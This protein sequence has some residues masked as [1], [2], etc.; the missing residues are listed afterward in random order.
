VPNSERLIL[1]GEWFRMDRLEIEIAYFLI[2]TVDKKRS[3]SKVKR[4]DF[5]EFVQSDP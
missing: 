3:K 5:G 2:E 4:R 1:I